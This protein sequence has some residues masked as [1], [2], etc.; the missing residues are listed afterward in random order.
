[1]SKRNKKS[2]EKILYITAI[3]GLLKEILSIFRA[4]IEIFVE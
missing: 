3:F 4:I 2:L 1:M